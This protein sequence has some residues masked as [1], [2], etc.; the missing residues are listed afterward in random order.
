MEL[1]N[2]YYLPFYVNSYNE[3]D[4]CCSLKFIVLRKPPCT[5]LRLLIHSILVNYFPA[6]FQF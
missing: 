3:K 4:H 1:P 5:K 2:I 6:I